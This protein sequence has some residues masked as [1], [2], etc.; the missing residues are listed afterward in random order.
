M[1][2]F[3]GKPRRLHFSSAFRAFDV[4]G[5]VV[6]KGFEEQFLVLAAGRQPSQG[7]EEG[8]EGLGLA[9]YSGS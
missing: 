9:A 7:G 5:L 6:V 8:T 3:W 2:N 4:S 1:G